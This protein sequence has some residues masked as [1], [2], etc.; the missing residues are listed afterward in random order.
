MVSEVGI[1]LEPFTKI[2]ETTMHQSKAEI[3]S[4]LLC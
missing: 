2:S 1:T 3:W 4:N